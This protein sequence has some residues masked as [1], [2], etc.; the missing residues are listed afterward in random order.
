MTELNATYEKVRE[1]NNTIHQEIL[2][3]LKEVERLQEEVTKEMTAMRQSQTSLELTV[4]KE[5]QTTRQQVDKMES[6]LTKQSEN[7]FDI[8]K[9][10]LGIQS[11]RT[12]QKHEFKM[13]KWNHV[14]TILIKFG[15]GI[16]LLLGS[17]T[18]LAMIIEHYFGK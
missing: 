17:G 4:M 6:T 18:A 10:S 11:T 16:T 13:A 9:A 5:S 7:L 15:G 12:T 1:H 3:R 8:V 14:A 2:P